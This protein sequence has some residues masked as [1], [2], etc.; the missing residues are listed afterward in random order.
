MKASGFNGR[1]VVAVFQVVL[2]DHQLFLLI[3][4]AD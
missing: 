3:L 1:E 2:E 4:P